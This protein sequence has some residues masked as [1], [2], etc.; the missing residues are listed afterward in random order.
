MKQDRLKS[1]NFIITTQYYLNDKT[2]LK[3][4]NLE[5]VYRVYWEFWEQSVSKEREG[6]RPRSSKW[7]YSDN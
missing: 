5:L 1:K 7:I 3:E 4:K 2:V 6:G